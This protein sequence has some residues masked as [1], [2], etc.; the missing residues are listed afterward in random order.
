MILSAFY[1]I[2]AKTYYIAI[3]FFFAYLALIC[4]R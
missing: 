4:I 1:G 2:A 3:H